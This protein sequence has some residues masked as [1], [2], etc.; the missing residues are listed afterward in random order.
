MT[1]DA[2]PHWDPAF[3][4]QSPSTTATIVYESAGTADELRPCVEVHAAPWADTRV[5]DAFFG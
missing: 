3:D 5:G 1:R 4:S 2:D